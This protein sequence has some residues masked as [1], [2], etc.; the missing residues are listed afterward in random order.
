MPRIPLPGPGEMNEAQ[1]A[2]YD[3]VVS[4]PRGEMIGPLRAVIHSPELATLWSNFGEYLRFRTC[5]PNRLNELAIIVTARRWSS[6]VEWWVHAKAAAK[7]GIDTAIIT[8]IHD[9]A[10]PNFANTDEADIYEFA[11]QLQMTGTVDPVTYDRV[12]A[13]HGARGVVEL[14]A[15]IGYYTMVSMMLNAHEI[16]LPDGEKP[17]LVPIATDGLTELPEANRP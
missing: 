9:G 5:L 6:Q 15:V 10:T 8:A 16:P 14:T 4:G 7:A 12:V 1:R 2:I 11:R 17:A 13:R 3:A